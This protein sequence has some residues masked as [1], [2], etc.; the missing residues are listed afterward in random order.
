MGGTFTSRWGPDFKHGKV[1]IV[2]NDRFTTCE[3]LFPSTVLVPGVTPFEEDD[4]ADDST[5]SDLAEDLSTVI[6]H[7]N[8]D[9]EFLAEDCAVPG[10]SVISISDKDYLVDTE[11]AMGLLH[12]IPG[13]ATKSAIIKA[14]S[15]ARSHRSPSDEAQEQGA[16]YA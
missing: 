13:Y 3:G 4:S 15:K 9:L 8:L 14:L 12:A 1:E 2:P 16:P 5:A 6:Q 7:A 10:I 11:K